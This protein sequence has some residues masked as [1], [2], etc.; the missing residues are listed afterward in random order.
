MSGVLSFSR[1]LQARAAAPLALLGLLILLAACGKGDAP[2][3]QSKAT[4]PVERTTI[5]LAVDRPTEALRSAGASWAR[6]EGV[7]LKVVSRNAPEAAEASLAELLGPGE[8][9]WLLEPRGLLVRLDALE[10]LGMGADP[11]ARWPELSSLVA[12][13]GRQGSGLGLPTEAE[14]LHELL[15]PLIW[16]AQPDSVVSS[17]TSTLLAPEAEE[18]LA[19]LVQLS[20]QALRLPSSERDEAFLSGQVALLPCGLEQ[21]RRLQA[22]MPSVRMRLWPWPAAP[23]RGKARA[24]GILHSLAIPPGASHADLAR[25]LAR[26]LAAADAAT[27]VAAAD[28]ACVPAAPEA[29]FELALLPGTTRGA[30]RSW[31]LNAQEAREAALLDEACDAALDLRRSPAAALSE[32]S[33][34]LDR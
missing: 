29:S 31:P 24:L 16:S 26:E 3:E 23:E 9:A 12:E 27:A 34:T 4:L 14:G 6:K 15:L 19:F 17:G 25:S 20:Q 18:A 21:A 33:R 7:D 22:S 13:L 11:P 1:A 8:E 2:S 28:Q 32:A 5:L 30:L 10:A